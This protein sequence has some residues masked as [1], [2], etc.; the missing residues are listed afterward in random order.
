MRFTMTFIEEDYEELTAHLF[1]TPTEAAAY[2][3]CGIATTPDEVRLLVREVIPVA[4]EEI[5]HASEVHMQ[6][7]QASFLRAIK[8]AA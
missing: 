7:Q 3:L 1:R 8:A 5:D 2:L 6:I 4:G